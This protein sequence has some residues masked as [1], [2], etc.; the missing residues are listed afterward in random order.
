MSIPAYERSNEAPPGV[1]YQRHTARNVILGIVAAIVFLPLLVIGLLYLGIVMTAERQPSM[2]DAWAATEHYYQALQRQ[3]YMTAYTYL[4]QHI[5]MTVDG[6]P[7]VVDS[8]TALATV[9]SSVDQQYGP[10]T[11]Y[12]QTD[13]NFEQ[14]KDVVDQT[15]HVTRANGE[16]DVHIK[17]KWV[18]GNQLLVDK[19]KWRIPSA[20]GL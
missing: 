16:Y 2:G 1:V 13:A 7:V 10:I 4:D 5:A 14:G 8:A 20:D 15:V 11:S 3:D 19:A 17:I 9:A 6:R 12:A 18:G